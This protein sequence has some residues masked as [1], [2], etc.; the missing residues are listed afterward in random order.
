[1]AGRISRVATAASAPLHL[2]L[3]TRRIDWYQTRVRY[4]KTENGILQASLS[5]CTASSK[6]QLPRLFSSNGMSSGCV[7]PPFSKCFMHKISFSARGR[8]ARSNPNQFFSKLQ[9][10]CW[11]PRF[12]I[13]LHLFINNSIGSIRCTN[14][15][16]KHNGHGCKYIKRLS[17]TLCFVPSHK[18]N[19]HHSHNRYLCQAG[20]LAINSTAITD[21]KSPFNSS[22]TLTVAYTNI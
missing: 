4:R 19:K 3:P 6:F 13:L 20:I 2:C 8:S 7:S 9:L 17:L 10:L 11:T 5:N 15:T 1:M 12:A 21:T 16:H 14:M 22:A 18:F